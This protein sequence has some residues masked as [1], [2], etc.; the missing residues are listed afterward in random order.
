MW[1]LGPFE[2]LIIIG[3]VLCGIV[4]ILRRRRRRVREQVARRVTGERASSSR[5]DKALLD[6]VNSRINTGARKIEIPAQ[7]VAGAS[8]E[9]LEEMRRLLKVAGV[10][11]GIVDGEQLFSSGADRALLD[12]VNSHINTGAR[13]MMIPTHL[14][15]GA[16]EEC[17]VE[18]HRL[19]KSAGMEAEILG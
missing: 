5:A 18:M 11:A 10:E 8:E 9:C 14:V 12:H 2:M 17:L 19:L 16:S 4:V 13:K 1:T 15:G 6:Y 3:G 7:L